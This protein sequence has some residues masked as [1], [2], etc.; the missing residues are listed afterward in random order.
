MDLLKIRPTYTRA[1]TDDTEPASSSPFGHELSDYRSLGSFTST[2]PSTPSQGYDS[3]HHLLAETSET[4]SKPL[5]RLPASRWWTFSFEGW[6]TGAS[7]AAVLAFISM[8][9]NL[10]VAGWLASKGENTAIVEVYNGD[11][12][13]V[14]RADIWVHLAINVLST[15][16]LGGSNFCS[17]VAPFAQSR[18][19][20][21]I[22][23]CNAFVRRRVSRLTDSTAEV[24]ISTSVCPVY[25]T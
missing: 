21:D 3:R 10:S 1:G 18:H 2:K 16:L 15:A 9:V 11:C 25:A 24:S 17:D 23:Q 22:Q 4:P 6:R 8:A 7:T 12:D 14:T 19:C 20:T 13:T 5:P